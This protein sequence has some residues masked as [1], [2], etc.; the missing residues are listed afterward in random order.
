MEVSESKI[1]P[2]EYIV[3]KSLKWLDSIGEN[4]SENDLSKMKL[5][6]ILFFLTTKEHKLLKNF[7]DFYALPHGPVESDILKNINE[8]QFS[9]YT[10]TGSATSLKSGSDFLDYEVPKQD[11]VELVNKAFKDLIDENEKLILKGAYELADLSHEWTCWKESFSKAKSLGLKAYPISS[12]QIEND[13]SWIY[14]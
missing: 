5:Q 11:W 1:A 8:N 7:C 9:K 3:F 13:R 4:V 12:T 10:I 14:A 6:K 2:F